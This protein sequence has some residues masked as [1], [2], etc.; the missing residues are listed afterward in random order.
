MVKV[1]IW[2]INMKTFK[3][4][5]T[6]AKQTKNEPLDPPAL[7][8]MRRKSIRNFPNNERVALY[9]IDKL[10]KY[11]SIPYTGSRWSSPGSIATPANESLDLDQ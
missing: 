10:K 2:A 11:I 5:Y 8:V 1:D 4:F 6:E 7:L 3:E 9:F